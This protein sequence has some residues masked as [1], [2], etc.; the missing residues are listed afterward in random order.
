MGI[1]DAGTADILND[2]DFQNLCKFEAIILGSLTDLK[3]ALMIP[4]DLIMGKFYLQ[5]ITLP[6]SKFTY[7]PINWD[8]V[9]KQTEYP[10]TITLKFL[11]TEEGY[12][13]R[14]LTLWKDLVA[15][16][17]APEYPTLDKGFGN[18]GSIAS[19]L[20]GGFS[21]KQRI[22]ND[23]QDASKKTIW[24]WP[25]PADSGFPFQPRRILKGVRPI[26]ISEQTWS[27]GNKDILMYEVICTIDDVEIPLLI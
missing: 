7:E 9:A 22:Y 6:D 14:Y 8:K 11:E 13:I 25:Q 18:L 17:A 27:Q 16:P 26:E 20:L 21:G 5:D 23:N 12:V 24:L 3:A 2:T 15:V 4:L 19:F 1:Y 10:E